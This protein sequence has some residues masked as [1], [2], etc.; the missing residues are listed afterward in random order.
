MA[1]AAEGVIPDRVNIAAEILDRRADAHRGRAAF[2]WEGGTI[3][4]DALRD[5]A[6]RLAGALAAAGLG[7]GATVLL[8]MPNCIE[9]A[10]TFLALS[11][12][13]AVPVLVNS[14]LGQEEVDYVLDHSGAEAAVTLADIAGPVLA[15]RDRARVFLW[16]GAHEG[17]ASLDGA[18]GAPLPP[19]A[20]APST[21]WA[22]SA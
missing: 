12:I 11:R 3:T 20:A 16:R 2:V 22:T 7:R 1:R 18:A 19:T 5:R 13:G 6:A 9:F 10:L 21:T 15:R 4:H 17:A 14:L 8:R